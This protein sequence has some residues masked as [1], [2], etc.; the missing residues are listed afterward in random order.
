M[1]AEA[2][3][4][5]HGQRVLVKQGTQHAAAGKEGG[6]VKARQ[7]LVR[8]L[9]TVAGDEAVYQL[10]IL[11]MQ[12]LIVQ[13]RLFQGVL[14][15]VGDE[16]VGT[17]NKLFQRL[18]A[19][20]ALGVENHAGLVG[21]FQIVRGILLL[22]L[23]TAFVDCGVPQRVA[24]GSLDLNH[25]GAQISQIAGAAG[26]GNK[27]GQLHYLDA[28]QWAFDLVHGC[29]SCIKDSAC[30]GRFRCWCGPARSG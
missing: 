28:L 6:E 20:G 29:S 4:G 16:N 18:A 3:N 10:G 11:C 30:R 8:T 1:V 19:T 21:V 17:G 13:P 15:P 7:I 23:R 26:G 9:F 27:G 14:T 12:R 5:Q 22:I 2:R 25:L 24:C